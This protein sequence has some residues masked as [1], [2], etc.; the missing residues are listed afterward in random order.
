MRYR[1]QNLEHAP[2]VEHAVGE[3]GLL[4]NVGAIIELGHEERGCSIAPGEADAGELARVNE[5]VDGNADDGDAAQPVSAAAA[6]VAAAVAAPESA[7]AAGA[8]S[9]SAEPAVSEATAT[10]AV[11]VE[12]DGTIAR[13]R[14]ELAS[15]QAALEAKAAELQVC[16]GGWPRCALV[17]C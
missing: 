9:P 11:V 8:A 15:A 12:K 4:L 16:G 5:L 14:E 1:R 17:R 10:A 6:S 7:A 2:L 3:I 13:L